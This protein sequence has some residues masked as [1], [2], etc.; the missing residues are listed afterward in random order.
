MHLADLAPAMLKLLDATVSDLKV[1][2]ISS[3][4]A[5]AEDLSFAGDASY[6]AIT[7]SLGLQLVKD[8]AK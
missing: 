2:N 8:T 6:D 5:N 1:P 3:S 7:F 4:I